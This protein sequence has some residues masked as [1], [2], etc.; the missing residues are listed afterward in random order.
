MKYDYLIRIIFMKYMKP[1]LDN[2]KT[3]NFA[4]LKRN[5]HVSLYVYTCVGMYEILSILNK[6]QN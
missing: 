4:N 6:I 5:V 3:H 1:T 2:N